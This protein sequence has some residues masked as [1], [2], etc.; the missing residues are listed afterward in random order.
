MFLPGCAS[1]TLISPIDRTHCIQSSHLL[2]TTAKQNH[3][4]LIAVVSEIECTEECGG[5][6]GCENK[7]RG[8]KKKYSTAKCKTSTEK[9]LWALL[10]FHMHYNYLSDVIYSFPFFHSIYPLQAWMTH[11]E[12]EPLKVINWLFNHSLTDNKPYALHLPAWQVWKCELYK[13]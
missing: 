10:L 13:Y 7:E 1:K 3:S 12:N 4:L 8:E 6:K 9:S 2:R 5:G 11:L